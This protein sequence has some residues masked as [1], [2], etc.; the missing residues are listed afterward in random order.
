MVPKDN[1]TSLGTAGFGAV[2]ICSDF[3]CELGIEIKGALDET[4]S[5]DMAQ[6]LTELAEAPLRSG[7]LFQDGQILNNVSLPSFPRFDMAMLV[8]WESA[9]GFRFPEPLGE[10]GCLRVVPLFAT[11]ADFVESHTDRH[12]GYRALRNRGMDETDPNRN[13]II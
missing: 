2:A 3:P 4:S 8:D 11:E 9:Y 5:A 6:A 1:L 12:R 7:Q 13:A 10:I